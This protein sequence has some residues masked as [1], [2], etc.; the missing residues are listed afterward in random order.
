MAFSIE[1][2]FGPY[3]ATCN[4]RRKRACHFSMCTDAVGVNECDSNPCQN[5]AA[6]SDGY[7]SYHCRCTSEFT[8]HTCNR[9]ESF[10]TLTLLSF[11]LHVRDRLDSNPSQMLCIRDLEV[12]AMGHV[13]RFIAVAAYIVI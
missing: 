8:G 11:L 10:S 12:C 9:R 3:R 4:E 13:R 2:A 7:M 1:F 5:G 6:C